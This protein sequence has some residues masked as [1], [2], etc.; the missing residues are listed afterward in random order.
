MFFCVLLV[1]RQP[2][3]TRTDTLL[4]YTTLFRSLER[5]GF[6]TADIAQPYDVV[7]VRSQHR[8]GYLAFLQREHG[9]IEG[10]VGHAL[11]QPAKVATL[12]DRKS[13]R[14]NSRH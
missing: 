14:L 10:R 12:T 9:R 6:A 3:F 2:R 11:F 1:R 5:L 7:T 4:P 8:L 13:K